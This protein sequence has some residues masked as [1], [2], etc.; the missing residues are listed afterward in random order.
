MVRVEITG[1]KKIERNGK[2][3][4]YLSALAIDP[5]DEVVGIATYNAFVRA[6]HL[7]KYKVPEGSLVGLEADYYNVKDGDTWKSGITFKNKAGAVKI[8]DLNNEFEECD[9]MPA[10]PF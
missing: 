9:D 1:Y 3:L 8:D 2:T 4:Y 7:K 5:I 6:S 10:L